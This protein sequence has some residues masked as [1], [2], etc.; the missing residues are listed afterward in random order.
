MAELMSLDL[1]EKSSVT[2]RISL[3]IGYDRDFSDKYTEICISD[4]FAYVLLSVNW[5]N[6][7]NW[8]LFRMLSDDIE[9]AWYEEVLLS[10]IHI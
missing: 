6:P 4:R 7:I 10:L 9:L 5:I 3:T 8:W 2:D 1:V